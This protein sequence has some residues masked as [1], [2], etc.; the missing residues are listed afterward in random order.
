MQRLARPDHFEVGEPDLLRQFYYG[1]VQTLSKSSSRVILL[2]GSIII[3]PDC[4]YPQ[5]A[6]GKT[7]HTE[8]PDNT[9]PKQ[10][11]R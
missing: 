9:N 5:P 4:A 8:P 11:V 10:A 2:A 3:Q 6:Q 7:N 1:V